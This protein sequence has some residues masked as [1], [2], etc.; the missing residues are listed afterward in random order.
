MS[1]RPRSCEQARAWASLR[2]DDE[3]SELES[4]LLDA[5]LLRCLSCSSF[6]AAAE[7][8]AAALRTARLERPEPL[9]VVTGSA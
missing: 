5:H 4:A 1:A 6:A 7:E 9:A 2:A 8:V 3:L